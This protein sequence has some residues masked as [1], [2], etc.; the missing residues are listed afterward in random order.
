MHRIIPVNPSLKIVLE[1][2]VSYRN[3]MPIADIGKADKLF[4]VNCTGKSITEVGVLARF[5]EILKSSKIP[6]MGK[7]RGPRVHDLRHSFAVHSLHQM[8]SNGMDIY[9]ALPILSVF[10]GHKNIYDTE[11]YVRMTQEIF[12]DLVRIQEDIAA[13][14]FPTSL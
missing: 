14:V 6:Y 3:K 13:F 4:F 8:V 11:W 9:C 2:Y 10:L 7:N 1:D 5:K 12:H